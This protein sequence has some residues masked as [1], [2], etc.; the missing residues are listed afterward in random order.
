MA[1]PTARVGTRTT[2]IPT[3]PKTAAAS[4]ALGMPAATA[5]AAPAATADQ[6]LGHLGSPNPAPWD[7]TKK[8]MEQ[9]A[10]VVK[11]D[12]KTDEN[13]TSSV[14]TLAPYQKQLVGQALPHAAAYA[15]EDISIP[16]SRDLVADFTDPQKA[17]QGI[18]L[19]AAQ[20]QA[21]LVGRG[22]GTSGFLLDPASLTAAGNPMEQAA[23]DAAVRPIYQNLQEGVLPQLRS[24]AAAAG[25]YG[26]SRQGIAEGLA[27]GRASQAAGDT[28][29][30][31]AESAY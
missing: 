18:A 27:S 22:A 19:Q 30:K 1:G 5:S 10:A 9:A 21:G 12:P 14:V 23:I 2:S 3:A 20:D 26:S 4:Q 13:T 15:R 25:Q 28:A 8:Q 31:I 11:K 7:P 6:E 16:E 17:G 29:A 24:G